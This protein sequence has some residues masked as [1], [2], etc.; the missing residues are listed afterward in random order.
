[1]MKNKN[2][3]IKLLRIWEILRQDTDEE[4]TMSTVELMD[5][6]LDEGIVCE[7]KSVYDD[8]RTLQECGYPVQVKRTRVNEYYAST[9]A[10]SMAELRLLIDSVQAAN[11]LSS[12]KSKEL[13]MKLAALGGN[14]RGEKL[15]GSTQF[16][17]GKRKDDSAT[18]NIETLQMALERKRKV[19]FRYFHL[20]V[21][22]HREYRT[23]SDGSAWYEVSPKSLVYRDDN[24]YMLC[25]M[26]E[27]EHYVTYRV[28][29]M[30]DVTMLRDKCDAPLWSKEETVAKYLKS[31]FGM[32]AGDRE[33]VTMLGKNEPKV[34]DMVLDRFGF[35]VTLHDRGD[36]TFMFACDVQVSPVFFAWVLTMG[37]SV[38][39]VAPDSVCKRYI[40]TLQSELLAQNVVVDK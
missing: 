33:R 38:K 37:D 15:R 7:R 34:I 8:I 32:F 13:T 6:L 1:M 35:D 26:P 25:V 5:R 4:H 9:G 20:D 18:A 17:V 23:R 36:G 21:D 2:Q 31:T 3:K 19:R 10:F 16:L 11:F 29:R 14:A 12:N 24:Y 27:R 28:D 30:D 40:Q 22:K 39:L